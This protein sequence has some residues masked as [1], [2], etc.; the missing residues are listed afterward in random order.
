[1]YD[2][3]REIP[4]LWRSFTGRNPRTGLLVSLE[5]GLENAK[6]CNEGRRAFL[7]GNR[8][9]LLY[10]RCRHMGAH[11]ARDTAR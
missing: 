8:L 6:A 1:M 3:W 7:G 10:V 11:S 9:V 2:R 5:C 4:I